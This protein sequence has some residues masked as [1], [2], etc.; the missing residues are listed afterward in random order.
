MAVK[1]SV[2][3]RDGHVCRFC[4]FHA[5]R[6]LEA[7]V[8]GGNARDVD[9]MLTACQFCHQCFNLPE[10]VTMRSGVLLWLP[11]LTQHDLHHVA[12]EIYL[13]RITQRSEPWARKMFDALM[14][15]RE[16][17]RERLGTDDPK[18]LA[19]RLASKDPAEVPALDSEHLGGIRL[20]PL[21]RRILREDDLEFNQFPQVLAYWRS[22]NGPYHGEREFPWITMLEQVLAAAEG[23]AGT[24]ASLAAE[25]RPK[26]MPSY[27]S[28]GA[29]LLRDAAHFFRNVSGQNA[30][31]SEQRE[32]N[33]QTYLQVADLL[34][35]NPLENLDF[36]ADSPLTGGRVLALAARLL[37]DAAN[38]FEAVGSQNPTLAEQMSSN[39]E[40]YRELAHWV[41][42]D[43]LSKPDEDA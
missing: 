3:H 25:V 13:A 42:T 39:A 7:V 28:L 18:V 20:L 8:L 24:S 17:A 15:R 16:P 26:P 14:A 37:E 33:A 22:R 2:W 9:H 21:D 23:S 41:R 43:P 36:V 34:E 11:E 5:M 38:F 40:V 1:R 35:Q 32:V 31:L 6:Y 30:D 4:G 10:V 29:R 19:Q 27:A 12:R